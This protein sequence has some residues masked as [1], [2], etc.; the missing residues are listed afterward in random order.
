MA[1]CFTYRVQKSDK[2]F[3]AK[4]RKRSLPPQHNWY[5]CKYG[6]ENVPKKSKQSDD[7]RDTCCCIEKHS[8]NDGKSQCEIMHSSHS[9]ES[10]TNITWLVLKKG[11][12]GLKNIKILS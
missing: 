8:L 10:S 1:S 3:E 12:R 9:D 7:E 5:V 4:L 11:L 6:E 2:G